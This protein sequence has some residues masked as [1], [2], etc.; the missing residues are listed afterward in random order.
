MKPP[1]THVYVDG[2]NL[3]NGILKKSPE[4]KWLNVFALRE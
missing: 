4:Y 2:F 3:Y 1:R